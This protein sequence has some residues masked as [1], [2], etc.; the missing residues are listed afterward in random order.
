M[1]FGLTGSSWFLQYA[2]GSKDPPPPCFKHLQSLFYRTAQHSDEA[3][4][5]LPVLL[6]FH[7]K[8]DVVAY[9]TATFASNEWKQP[10]DQGQT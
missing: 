9:V 3:H 1:E 5:A 8:N 4:K 7:H 2:M 10:P 6:H